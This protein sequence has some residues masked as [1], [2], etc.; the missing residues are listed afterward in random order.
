MKRIAPWLWLAAVVLILAYLAFRIAGGIVLQSNILALLPRTERDAAAQSVEDRITNSFAK[1]VVF[2]VGDRAPEKAAAA[3]RKLSA[4]LEKSGAISALTSKIDADAQRRI[5]AAYFPYRSGLLTG[6]DR[7]DLLAGHGEKL[8]ARSQAMLYGPGGLAMAKLIGRDPFFLLPNFLLN[9]PTPQSRLAI[10]GDVLSVRDGDITY[11]LVSADLAGDPFSLQFQ[12]KFGH[13]V[14]D[15]TAALKSATPDLKILRTGAV[16]YA[17]ESADEA[18]NETTIIGFVSMAATLALIFIVFGGLRP[19]ILGFLSIA[20]GIVC[21]A[22]G[23]LLIFGQM[24]S[25]SLLFGVSLIGISVDYSLQYF[26]EYFDPAA[27]NPHERLRRVLPGVIIGLITTLI[28]YF[29]LWL[30]PFPGLQQV[31]AFSLIGLIASFLT[32]ALWYPY[33]DSTRAPRADSRTVRLAGKHWALWEAPRLRAARIAVIGICAAA[34]IAGLFVLKADDN[35]HHLQSMPADLTRQEDEIK[36]LTGTS[37]SAQFLLI[38]AKDERSLLETEERIA[39]RLSDLRKS[40]ALDGYTAMSQ[41]VPSIARQKE[42]RALVREKLM[43]PFLPAYLEG[44]SYQGKIDYAEPKD[45]LTPDKLPKAGPLSLLPLLDIGTHS[46]PAHVILLGGVENIAAIDAQIKNIPG[47]RLV[48]LADDWSRLFG[49]YRRYAVGLLALSVV[50]MYPMLAWR[51]GWA[52]AL[53][54]L[55]PSLVAV[56]L[57]PPIAALMGVSFTFF[58]A[59]ALVLVLSIGV[60]YSVFCRESSGVRKPVTTLA[61]ALAALSTI[62]SFGMLAL[63]RVFAV[64]A[65]GMTMLIGIFLAFLFAPAAGSADDRK[66][67]AA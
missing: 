16:F 58:N 40:G 46:A 39:G 55:A 33:L 31:A 63:S 13:V 28:G 12:E 7:A 32:V 67:V 51:Y 57:A 23:T 17:H 30:A 36:G 65:F 2:L 5:G 26:C 38:R 59:M 1:R 53:R 3:A 47:V 24:H 27:A 43:S 41:F 54:V 45:F 50:L 34:G 48:S 52:Q 9:L 29:T 21:A 62:L 37:A 18:M 60:D 8:V 14:D 19:I 35:V 44:T 20:V 66:G 11:V 4:V 15:A 25:V 10:D 56:A 6:Q 61:I 42:N 22:V 49:N 64:H